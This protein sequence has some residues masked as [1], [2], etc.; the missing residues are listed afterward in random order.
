MSISPSQQLA[1]DDRWDAA[2]PTEPP[3]ARRR[4]VTH[5]VLVDGL[6]ADHWVEES[7][8][9]S[10]ESRGR[11][12]GSIR[13]VPQEPAHA[14]ALRWLEATVGGPQALRTL[15]ATPLTIE[16]VDLSTVPAQLHER[17]A[18][19]NARCDAIALDVFDNLELTAVF[20]SVLSAVLALDPGMLQRSDRDDTAAGAVVW[21]GGHANGLI[22]PH[23]V[24]LAR[25]LW[26]LL[27]ISSSAAARGAGIL[28]RLVGNGR[29]LEPPA[30]WGAPQLR[31]TGLPTALLGA[32]RATLL[33]RRDAA[34]ADRDAT[35]AA[36]R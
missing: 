6:P 5:V 24:L 2:E 25:D 22:G 9:G 18:A 1:W 12:R 33:A 30:S 35:R 11:R 10:W 29:D 28:N 3:V 13:L 31:P 32:T 17:V 36:G 23:G 8:D 7:I 20:R 21:I 15:D 34:W 4:L 26:D 16:P 19:I 14:Q 27:D